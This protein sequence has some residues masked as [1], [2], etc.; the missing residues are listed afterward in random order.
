MDYKKWEIKKDLS[1]N[2]K[3][4]KLNLTNTQIGIKE[5]PYYVVK[6]E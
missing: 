2:E 3:K 6:L 1:I 4:E 5:D